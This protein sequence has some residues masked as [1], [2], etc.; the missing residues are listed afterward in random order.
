MSPLFY[1]VNTL[2]TLCIYLV[3]LR[4]WMQYTRVNYYNPFTQFV[5]KVT[6]P[7]IGPLRILVPAIGKFDTASFIVLYLLSLL[8]L[9]TILYFATNAPYFSLTYLLYCCLVAVNALGHLIFWILLVR[10]ILS[11][12][13]RGQSFLEDVLAQLSEPLIAPIR[14]I[15]PPIGGIDV[16]F[17]I[18]VF[19]L[20]VLN[21][22]MMSLFS[23]WWGIVSI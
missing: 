7:V 9:L 6:Q 14:R 17:M 2:L 18:F 16:S 3:I 5:I 8:K 10:A 15:V 13:S 4:V 20:I 21:M 12:V 19:A 23:P 22:L 11:W 1:I